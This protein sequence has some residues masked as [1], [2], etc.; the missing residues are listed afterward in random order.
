MCRLTGII[1]SILYDIQRYLFSTERRVGL[2]KAESPT[3]TE[4]NGYR[5]CACFSADIVVYIR[6]IHVDSAHKTTA[7]TRPTRVSHCASLHNVVPVRSI[8]GAIQIPAQ[9]M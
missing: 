8:R 7:N 2:I 5:Q 1:E 6:Y 3:E 9:H 4:R